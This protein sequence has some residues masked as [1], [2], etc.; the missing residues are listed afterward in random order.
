MSDKKNVK[1][2]NKNLQVSKKSTTFAAEKGFLTPFIAPVV[3][4]K[5]SSVPTDKLV[6]NEALGLRDLFDR[7]QRGQR[8]DVHTRMRTDDCPDNMYRA[9]FETDPNTGETRMKPD[10]LE[11]TLDN[12]PPS[13]MN[14]ITDVQAYAREVAARKK[15]LQEKRKNDIANARRSA[16]A[17]KSEGKETKKPEETKNE[18]SEAK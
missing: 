14:D 12:V 2:D 15:E 4:E 3:F 8:L 18:V 16:P 9:E 6:P 7:T 13:Q 17:Q 1:N 11:E 10:S 5:A